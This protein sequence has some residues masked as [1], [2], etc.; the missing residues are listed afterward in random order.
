MKTNKT[1]NYKKKYKYILGI[2]CFA[3]SDSGAAIFKINVAT[4]KYDYVAISEERLIRKKHP[5]TFPLHSIM[6]C[7]EFY[8]LKSL[9]ELDFII[10]DIIREKVWKRPQKSVDIQS[11]K[12]VNTR[13]FGG[14]D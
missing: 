10:S 13:I 14:Y 7:L 3:T 8:N 4:G 6:Y 9:K 12:Q 2:Q 11:I 5:Y 1:I